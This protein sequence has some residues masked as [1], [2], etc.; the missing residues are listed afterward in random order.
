MNEQIITGGSGEKHIVT[1][2]FNEIMFRPLSEDTLWRQRS[3][4]SDIFWYCHLLSADRFNPVDEPEVISFAYVTKP[5]DP[6]THIWSAEAHPDY[7]AGNFIQFALQF[8]KDVFDT[9]IHVIRDEWVDGSI[10]RDEYKQFLRQGM[11]TKEAASLTSMS[12]V[13][14]RFGFEVTAVD[15]N[16]AE[17]IVYFERE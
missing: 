17:P 16:Y 5:K 14:K 15:K 10:L 7:Y 11:T 3:K 2:Q 6:S 13:Y 1:M 8:Y 4:N 12:K 9:H